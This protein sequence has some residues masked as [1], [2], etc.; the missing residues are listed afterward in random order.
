MRIRPL[1][2]FAVAVFALSVSVAQARQAQAKP[3]QKPEPKADT[4]L[5]GKWNVTVESP[6]GSV[7]ATLDMKVDGKKIGGS[8]ASPQGEAKI[9]GEV[10]EG[11]LM[12]SFTMDAGG[13]QMSVTF[14]GAQQKDGT[15][16]GTL[17][18]GQGDVPWKAAKAK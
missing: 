2:L 5:T 15:L 14:K 3:E 4:A 8:I 17:D 13:Q 1:V 11:K 10:V 6:N 7:E 16:A 12:F 9:E 18:F